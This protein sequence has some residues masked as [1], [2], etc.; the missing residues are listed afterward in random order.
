M[1]A[2]S[3]M[4]SQSLAQRL[5]Q[6]RLPVPQ[7]LRYATLLAE[8]LRRLHESGRVHGA[9]S[10]SAILVTA[11]GIELVPNP[12]LDD[13]IPYQA[14]EVLAGSAPD[15][16]SDIFS[17]GVILYELLSGTRAFSGAARDKLPPS[18]SP[19]VDRLAGA[20][21]AL[22][23][24]ARIQRIQKVMLDLKLLAVSAA[25][26]SAPATAMR[27]VEGEK[28]LRAEVE[29]TEARWAARMQMVESGLRGE[30]RQLEGRLAAT[31]ES[32]EDMRRRLAELHRTLSGD[33]GN[34]RE[35]LQAQAAA[36][37]SA[38]TAVGQTD[39]LVERVVDALENLQ[40]SLLSGGQAPADN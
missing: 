22:D 17:F 35:S 28:R 37:E 7:A 11:T 16:R 4:N 10:P 33:L 9:L 32:V 24:A 14:P 26:A 21:A 23:P 36:I 8:A 13:A 20:C 15:A 39:E 1:L 40:A 27:D 31:Q 19:A 38:Q 25:R 30:I 18:G 2:S 34:L 29:Q 6:G 3:G 5:S 12:A